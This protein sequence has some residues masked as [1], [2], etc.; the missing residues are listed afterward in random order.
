MPVRRSARARSRTGSRRESGTGASN[1]TKSLPTPC[2]F[3]NSTRIAAQHSRN[4][5]R[6]GPARPP[7]TLPRRLVTQRRAPLE[8]TAIHDRED[9]RLHRARGGRLI[10]HTLLQ[11]ERR[12]LQAYAVVH[13]ARDVL[14]AAE[15][16]DDVDPLI[17]PEYLRHLRE[18]GDR[19]L[20]EY[21]LGER[22]HRNDPVTETLQGLRHAMTRP[23]AVR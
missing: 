19:R 6:A 13:D 18:R 4:A 2:I 11:P 16:I 14:A 8:E 12:E 21:E 9:P 15:N 20:T 10:D 22:V 7:G 1:T 3:V 17:G 5:A 23:R